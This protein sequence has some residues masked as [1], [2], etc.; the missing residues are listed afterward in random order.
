M[1]EA[2]LMPAGVGYDIIRW[3]EQVPGTLLLLGT[4][5]AS[6]ILLRAAPGSRPATTHIARAAR[7]ILI[8]EAVLLSALLIWE[9]LTASLFTLVSFYALAAVMLVIVYRR[10]PRQT[11]D[12]FLASFSTV[13]V[14]LAPLA[15]LMPSLAVG[16][17]PLWH[18][19]LVVGTFSA[20]YLGTVL[21]TKPPH[22]SLKVHAL[23]TWALLSI[24]AV[25]L[26][27][28]IAILGAGGLTGFWLPIA[29]LLPSNMP[30]SEAGGISTLTL[31]ALLMLS[32][33]LFPDR[34]LMACLAV[35]PAGLLL[36]WIAL[37]VGGTGPFVLLMPTFAAMLLCAQLLRKNGFATDSVEKIQTLEMTG[38]AGVM[39]AIY[40]WGLFPPAVP[41]YYPGDIVCCP[42]TLPTPVET[43]PGILVLLLATAGMIALGAVF[44]RKIYALLGTIGL[45]AASLL[46]IH[47]LSYSY[48]LLAGIA[49]L[50][51]VVALVAAGW[52]SRS[53]TEP[54][55]HAKSWKTWD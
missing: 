3:L 20:V 48:P 41:S 51:L 19:I 16:Y 11:A 39:M 35:V 44:K 12:I 10:A 4:A 13:M 18:L 36:T 26:A 29:G 14:C 9:A 52:Q 21:G 33:H 32:N 46:A 5:V 54:Q 47:L 49:C 53:G 15:G 27:A 43:G 6:L 8:A 50:L 22:T 40:Q 55:D 38:I 34:Q 2:A 37:L 45:F 7:I 25:T 1:E 23:R 24:A 17:T 30:L 42:N 28:F 31:I